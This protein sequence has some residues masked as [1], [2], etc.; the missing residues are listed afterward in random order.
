MLTKEELMKRNDQSVYVVYDDLE[1]SALVAY[2]ADE[3]DEDILYLTNN[4]GDRS[5]YEDVIKFGGKIYPNK[6]WVH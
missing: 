4:L 5:P 2:H 3:E 1:F 6:A